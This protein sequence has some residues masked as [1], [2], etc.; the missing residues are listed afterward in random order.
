[1]RDV[2]QY[3]PKITRD[4]FL[5]IGFAECKVILTI[6]ILK[7]CQTKHNQLTNKPNKT[8]QRTKM[9]SSFATVHTVGQS[10]GIGSVWQEKISD[11]SPKPHLPLSPPASPLHSSFTNE[12]ITIIPE[13]LL[14]VTPLSTPIKGSTTTST[15]YNMLQSTNREININIDELQ[16][17]IEIITVRSE[18]T[19]ED[20]EDIGNRGTSPKQDF[21]SEVL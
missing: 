8:R 18:E 12:C 5:S 21:I 19:G 14:E 10:P 17:D 15:E 2:F 7:H 1:M 9:A 13:P 4:Q 20:T 3:R 11:I 16:D 6:D